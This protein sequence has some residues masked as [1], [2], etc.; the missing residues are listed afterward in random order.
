MSWSL[1][2]GQPL[3]F[4]EERNGLQGR[5]LDLLC[6]R[7]SPRLPLPGAAS[8]SPVPGELESCFSPPPHTQRLPLEFLRGEAGEEF[9]C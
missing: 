1:A 5:G 9:Y 7:L 4:R 8:V 3:S 2:A 6:P